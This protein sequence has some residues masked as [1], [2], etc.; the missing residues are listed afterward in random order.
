[1]TVQEKSR[2]AGEARGPHVDSALRTLARE[3]SGLLALA[4]ALDG[5]IGRHF[6]AAVE[7]VRHAAGRVIVTGIGKSGHIGR[8]IAAT[9]ASTGT[10]SFFVHAAEAVHGDLGIDTSDDVSLALAFS[11]EAAD[12]SNS[13]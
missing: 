4:E 5:S 12:L 10:P 7:L 1:M 2:Q 3:Q 8:K 13:I 6:D 11:G 9:F